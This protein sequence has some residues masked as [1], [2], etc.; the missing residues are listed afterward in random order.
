MF[1]PRMTT[2]VPPDV[3]PLSGSAVCRRISTYLNVMLPWL[4]EDI[5]SLY[6]SVRVTA[7]GP[8]LPLGGEMHANVAPEPPTMVA[9]TL[10]D[11][12]KVHCICKGIAVQ[13]EQTLA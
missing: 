9:G 13:L 4:I 12:S 3:G 8:A 10:A 5:V 1:A 6:T 2:K 7:T 11:R